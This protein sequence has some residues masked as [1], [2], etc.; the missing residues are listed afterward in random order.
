M[1]SAGSGLEGAQP[2]LERFDGSDPSLYKRWRRRAA[3]SLISLPSTYGATKLGPKL[4]EYLGGEAELA[5]EHLKIEDL[6]REGGEK[7]I[8]EVLDERYKPLE[9]D[10]MSEALKEFFFDVQIKQGEAMKSFITRLA[11]SHRKLVDQGVTLPK[12]VQGWFLLKKMRLDSNQEAMILTTTGGSYDVNEVNKAVRAVLAN[13]KGTAKPR[14]TFTVEQRAYDGTPELSDDEEVIQVLAADVQSRESY[15]DEEVVEVFETYKQVRAKMQEFKKTRGY[16]PMGTGSDAGTREPWKLRG[17]ISAKIEQIKSRTRCHKCGKYGHWKKEC[18][19]GASSHGAKSDSGQSKEV[20]IVDP[21]DTLG[22]DD[23]LRMFEETD[24][25]IYSGEVMS[26][27]RV[28]PDRITLDSCDERTDAGVMKALGHFP[29]K[30]WEV[31]EDDDD[32]GRSFPCTGLATFSNE[33]LSSESQGGPDSVIEGQYIAELSEHGVPDTACR[34][35]LIGAN[36]LHRMEEHVR[37]LGCRVVRKKGVNVFRFGNAESLTSTELAIIPCFIGGSKILLQVAVLPGSGSDTPLLM[38][39]ELLRELGAV[40]D[41]T[42]DT[43]MFRKLGNVTVRLGRTS[44]GHYALPLFQ[45]SKKHEVHITT[46]ARTLQS[47]S[48]PTVSESS[49]SD[50]ESSHD[51]VNGFE[52]RQQ[53]VAQ[54]DGVWSA[55]RNFKPEHADLRCSVGLHGGFAKESRSA[56]GDH[57]DGGEVQGHH[58]S[59]RIDDAGHLHAR[60]ELRAVGADAHHRIKRIDDEEVEALH[61]ASRPSEEPEDEQHGAG[62]SSTSGLGQPAR[63]GMESSVHPSACSNPEEACTTGGYVEDDIPSASSADSRQQQH[64][65]KKDNPGRRHGHRQSRRTG[66]VEGHDRDD[67]AHATG[68]DGGSTWTD[69]VDDGGREHSSNPGK[70][71]GTDGQGEHPTLSGR[72]SAECFSPLKNNGKEIEST[73]TGTESDILEELPAA[74]G[75]NRKTRRKLRRVVTELVDD[76]SSHGCFETLLAKEKEMNPKITEVFSVPRIND[77][78]MIG[79]GKIK[80]GSNYDLEL[81]D[82]LLKSE[83]REHVLR[84]LDEES[85]FLVTLSSPCTMF[86]TRR[87]PTGDLEY[88]RKKM[89]EAII[90]L[91][92]A[93]EVCR[94]QHQRGRYFLFEHPSRAR[95]WGSRRMKEL[96]QLPGVSEAVFDMCEYGMVDR[97]SGIPHKKETRLLGNL[98]IDIMGKFVRKCS[99]NHDH[100]AL[101]GKVKIGS[102]W[103]NRTRLAQEYPPDLCGKIIEL[104]EE[105][106]CRSNQGKQLKL[107]ETFAVDSLVGDDMKKIEDGVRK[108]HQNLGHPG[109]ERF[110]EMLR[111]AGANDKAIAVARKYKCSVCEAQSG[112]KL[113][114]VSKMRKTYEFN[115]GVVCDLFELQMNEK[116]KVHCLSVVCEGTN[117]H[118]VVPLWKGKTA[119]ETRKAYRKSWKNP[120]GSPIRLFTDGGSEFEGSFQEGLMLDGTADERSAAFA[121]W[122]NG[123]A[124]RHGQTWKSMFYKTV[125]GFAPQSHED[126][127][128]I[129]DQVT[130]AKNTML[131]RSGFSPYQRVYGKQPRIPGMVYDNGP[132]VVVNSGYLAGDPSYVKAVQIR[133]EA[134]KAFC[135]ADHEDR[136]RRAIEH[137]SRPERGPFYAGCKVFVWRPGGLKPSGDRAFYWRGPG[138]VIGNT[139]SSKYWVSFG[140]KVLK[141]APEQ[142]RRL[143]IQDEAAVKLVPEELVDWSYQSKSAK[144]VATFHDI[145]QEE[146]PVDVLQQADQQDYW[147]YTGGERMVRVH[148]TPRNRR[149]VPSVADMP[150]ISIEYLLGHRKTTMNFVTGGVE[151]VIMDDWKVADDGETATETQW[152]GRTA[153]V[154]DRTRRMDLEDEG[155]ERNV[156]P[157]ISMNVGDEDMGGGEQGGH[158]QMIPSDA[159]DLTV[160]PTTPPAEGISDIPSELE[161]FRDVI[162]VMSNSEEGRR[163]AESNNNEQT[164]GPIRMTGL[165]RAL[166]HDLNALDGHPTSSARASESLMTELAAGQ[167][168][169]KKKNWKIN[170]NNKTLVRRHDWRKKKFDPQE[171]EC[172]LPLSWLTGMRYTLARTDAEDAFE[173]Q[174]DNFVEK[175]D[176]SMGKWW[177]GY[178]VFEFDDML[179]L[180]E[181]EEGE[182]EVNEATLTETRYNTDEWTGKKTEMEKLQKYDAV[183][184]LNPRVA[185]RIRNSTS[186]ILPS[187]FVIT[188]KPDDKNPGQYITKARWC[189]RGYLDPDVNKLQTQSPTLSTEALALVLQLSASKNWDFGI[190]DIEGAFLQGESLHREQ[191]ELYVELPPGGA[192]GIEKGSLL[193]IKK[194]VYGLIDAPREWYTALQQT[195]DESGF[196]RSQLDTCLYY[197]WEKGEMIG[198]LA[199]HVDDII[200][201]GTELF[202]KKYMQ[203]LKDKYPFKHWKTNQG[204]FLGRYVQKNKDGSISINQQEYCEKMKTIELTRERRRERNDDLTERERS[205]L[206]G[207]AGALNWVTTATRP[208]LAAVTAS[209]QQKIATAKIG[210]IAQANQAVAEARDHKHVTICIR[211]IPMSDL[212][213]LVTADASWTSE[214]DLRSQGAYMVCAT[215]RDVEQGHPVQVSP[216]KWKSQKQERAVSSTLAAELLTVSKGVAE[217][218]W[219]R[220]FFYESMFENYELTND[221][222][223]C[224]NI[225]IIAV[226]DNKPLYDH[227]HAD[228][229]ICQDKRLAIEILLLRRDVRKYNVV[230][231]WIDTAQMLV[232]CM[233]KTRIKPQL[234]RHVLATGKYA[235]MEENAMLEAKRAHRHTQNLIK[236]K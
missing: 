205:Q 165:T 49:K 143:T 233:T 230:L 232:D 147:E 40:L 172:P 60:E 93:V 204:E 119:D 24:E 223:K 137:R 54:P 21:E 115:V 112:P 190:C 168:L 58:S 10:D 61:R 44:K 166:R 122:Q 133:H 130:L 59:K 234:M 1:A 209:V 77:H 136:V 42:E 173:V 160:T 12:E 196:R 65:G 180:G 217:A 95:S 181:L 39:K 236:K 179:A 62:K 26:S 231:R 29:G 194:A 226:T 104:A 106:F 192:P 83:H 183:E 33:A 142:L 156:R 206:R 84:K 213:I 158:E 15:S 85:P 140:S 6:A 63:I 186:R 141:C 182:F 227:I 7:R 144:G 111:A 157:R 202:Q 89:K 199:I 46:R 98:E 35:S 56:R 150:P 132:N 201:T 121:P 41:M 37:D 216:L 208:D 229:G 125:K 198:A 79:Q 195:M 211:A 184:I 92:F 51:V 177:S 170:W 45:N 187:R 225:P 118:V 188:R 30:T 76:L 96:M 11:T 27:E 18:K 200:F 114:K 99:G 101:E 20:H 214:N 197:A 169:D 221:E 152:T 113:Q 110:V 212:A 73:G 13:V 71:H 116:Q 48:D 55:T 218:T 124:E 146:K 207:V 139:D 215:T 36:V 66:K 34:R 210:D 105:Q 64:L 28:E 72:G 128:E 162:P 70:V 31:V 97:I 74:C 224:T 8:F 191:G 109:T 87:R 235:I 149:Y 32:D 107:M 129:M 78:H 159:S 189:I 102:E 2:R 17:T 222:R 19:Q 38:S 164:Y 16:R 88:E 163:Q 23:Y 103:F 171:R 94:Y 151:R 219:M 167:W 52:L 134:R 80:K 4:M 131:N 57:D 220:Q 5:V 145:S 148:V 75:M 154:V 91:N 69:G 228:H 43:M 185:E 126:Y 193:R 108:A 175:Q 127:E 203:K 86:S 135:D 9:K 176:V 3:L 155:Y 117:F 90:L 120:L 67:G 50:P 161:D 178:T 138:T 153:F 22:D 47:G 14:D 82:D 100:Q 174:E 53:D 25:M 68:R 123:I 81:G